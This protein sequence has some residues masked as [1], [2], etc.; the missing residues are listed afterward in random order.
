M[1]KIVSIIVLINIT[2]SANC[3]IKTGYS[4]NTL[5]GEGYL[6]D[7]LYGRVKSIIEYQYSL[8]GA[9]EKELNDKTIRVFDE[10]GK[11]TECADTTFGLKS[12]YFFKYDNNGKLTNKNFYRLDHLITNAKYKYDNI[13]NLIQID[14]YNYEGT[15][16][17]KTIFLYNSQNNKIKSTIYLPHKKIFSKEVWEYD[18][19]NNISEYIITGKDI[20]YLS[21]RRLYKYNEINKQ[22]EVD[23]YNKDGTFW[24]RT[25]KKYNSNGDIIEEAAYFDNNYLRNK[26][27]YN[28]G[29]QSTEIADTLY[30]NNGVNFGKYHYTYEAFDRDHN[31]LKVIGYKDGKID[32]IKEREIIYY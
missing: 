23:E 21:T 9:N 32:F 8:N 25:L 1:R 17:Q 15:I 5:I 7:T 3:Q 24:I 14:E 29:N 6:D 13:G 11:I 20:S 31:W 4:D 26:R 12:K 22:C 27:V 28:Y 30:S 10:K 16:S 2:L 18:S 19:K